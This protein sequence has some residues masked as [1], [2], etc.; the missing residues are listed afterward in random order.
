MKTAVLHLAPSLPVRFH[1]DFRR[2]QPRVTG[3]R[4]AMDGS[5]QAIRFGPAPSR[6]HRLTG[7]RRVMARLRW[8]VRLLLVRLLLVRRLDRVGSYYGTDRAEVR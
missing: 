6:N 4:R 7:P 5:H 1:M 8:L 3:N 2:D